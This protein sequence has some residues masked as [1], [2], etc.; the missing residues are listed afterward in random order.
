MRYRS[1]WGTRKSEQGGEVGEREQERK[2]KQG[3]THAD[4]KEKRR[5]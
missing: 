1:N 4:G 3:E 5:G 2:E